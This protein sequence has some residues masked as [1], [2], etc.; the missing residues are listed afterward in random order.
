[1]LTTL[2]NV[3]NKAGNDNTEIEEKSTPDVL[4]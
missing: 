4:P 3:D 1:M 2:S